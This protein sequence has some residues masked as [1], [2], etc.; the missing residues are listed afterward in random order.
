MRITVDTFSTL[1]KER[2]EDAFAFST[3]EFDSAMAQVNPHIVV[4][5]GSPSSMEAWEGRLRDRGGKLYLCW[6]TDQSAGKEAIVGHSF[7]IEVIG[8]QPGNY[9]EHT[10]MWLCVTSAA[11][12]RKGIM[13][14]LLQAIETETIQDAQKRLSSTDKDHVLLTVNTI[15]EKFPSMPLFL[16]SSSFEL[17]NVVSEEDGAYSRQRYQKKLLLIK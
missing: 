9:E 14:R 13:R 12:R 5:A 6:M 15:P 17:A 7:T 10:H 1:T 8:K 4:P 3:R 11:H 16:I 2:L